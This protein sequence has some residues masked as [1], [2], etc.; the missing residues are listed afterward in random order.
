MHY[1]IYGKDENCFYIIEEIGT[2]NPAKLDPDKIQP[3]D[4]SWDDKIKHLTSPKKT[5]D[6]KLKHIIKDLYECWCVHAIGKDYYEYGFQDIPDDADLGSVAYF[7]TKEEA[8]KAIR[9]IK[10]GE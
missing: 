8:E 4:I 10:T 6:I 2:N 5:I 9:T 3:V 1:K 7:H